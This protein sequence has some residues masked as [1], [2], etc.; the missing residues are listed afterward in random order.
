MSY[1]LSLLL[2]AGG[3]SAAQPAND[4]LQPPPGLV[5]MQGG[6]TKIGIDK[7]DVEKMLE[8]NLA[9]M[10]SVTALDAETPQ[11]IVDL[12][13]FHLMV[14]E[15]TNEQYLEFVK[16]TGYRRPFE[17]G[18]AA[19]DKARETSVAAGEKNF[20]AEGWWE[21][22]WETQEYEVK[23]AEMMLPVCYISHA[24][25]E[26][27]C[28][29]AGLRLPS[30]QELQNATR[31]TGDG[32]YPWGKEPADPSRAVTSAVGGIKAPISVGAMPTGK[33]AQG[34]YD[35]IGN[36]WEWSSSPFMA[37][38][39][40]KSSTYTTGKGKT[41]RRSSPSPTGTATAA[42]AAGAAMTPRWSPRA[43]PSAAAPTAP[44]APAAWASAPP[45]ARTPWRTAP[46]PRTAARCACR[47]PGPTG[48]CSPPNAPTAG[49][50]GT[51]APPPWTPLRSRT[52]ISPCAAC[53][54][55][56][57]GTRSPKGM[58]SSPA[59]TT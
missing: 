58:R 13:P 44:S 31:G 49:S 46:R 8:E 51:A 43:A 4:N 40:W 26:A 42:W 56:P 16:A 3:T 35:L 33:S 52:S 6:R 7:K 41:R 2:V 5:P 38:D 37:Y 12:P 21:A 34:I 24:D 22:N 28:A 55:S 10:T 29:W 47:P 20:D 23:P 53:P 54:P 19:V 57:R 9:L 11:H 45:L 48:R 36:A 15:V 50:G 30:E 17:W 32:Y 18:A 59:S 14:T 39:G 1:L 27:Y 25:S